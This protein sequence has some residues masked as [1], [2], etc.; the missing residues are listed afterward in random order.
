MYNELKQKTELLD[1]GIVDFLGLVYLLGFLVNLFVLR[2]PQL[3]D[4]PASAS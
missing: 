2:Q 1:R 4:L 3:G